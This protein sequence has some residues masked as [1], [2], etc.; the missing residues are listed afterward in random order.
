MI[1]YLLF[2]NSRP[3]PC[4]FSKKKTTNHRFRKNGFLTLE[5][6]KDFFFLFPKDIKSELVIIW[7]VKKSLDALFLF[8]FVRGGAEKSSKVI[9][10]LF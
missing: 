10:K 2:S 4:F 1:K 8:L 7:Q 9:K 3:K 6:E 5:T